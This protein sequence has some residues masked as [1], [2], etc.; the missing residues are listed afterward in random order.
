MHERESDGKWRITKVVQPHTCLSNK[1]KKNH[2]QLTARYLACRILRLIDNNND[3]SM[4]SLQQSIS[5][6]VMYD[7]KYGKLGVLSRLP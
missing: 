5:G 2:Q 4:S 7:V 3:I 1:G 6:F